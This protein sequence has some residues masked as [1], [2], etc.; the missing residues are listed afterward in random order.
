MPR[1]SRQN[2][3]QQLVELLAC[4]SSGT[5][6]A[7]SAGCDPKTVYRRQQDPDFKAN[8]E[9]FRSN[10][11]D[12]AAGQLASVLKKTICTLEELLGSSQPSIRLGACRAILDSSLKVRDSVEM[13][14]RIRQLEEACRIGTEDGGN[15]AA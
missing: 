1:K 13:E 8:V 10:M 15:R 6:A 14:Q 2:I 9:K 5:E 4:G 11:L 7:R 3:D 12:A